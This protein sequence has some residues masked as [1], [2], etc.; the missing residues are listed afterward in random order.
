MG[1][2]ASVSLTPLQ[3]SKELS[4]HVQWGKLPDSENEKYVVSYFLSGQGPDSSL[5]CP[6]ILVLGYWSTGDK[7]PITLSWGWRDGTWTSCL[8]TMWGNQFLKDS[9]DQTRIIFF[10]QSVVIYHLIMS[11][12]TIFTVPAM[13][14]VCVSQGRK[15]HGLRI[16]LI[17]LLNCYLA[18]CVSF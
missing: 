17:L 1:S 7:S 16:S 5:N 12:V 9:C 2:L 11:K 3:T 4:V 15:S 8:I 10:S 13:M 18:W 6:A 14:W